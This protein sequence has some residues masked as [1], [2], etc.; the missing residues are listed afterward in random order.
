MAEVAPQRVAPDLGHGAGHLDA[1]RAA[2][3]DDEGQIGVAA[4]GVGLPFG[5][6]ESQQDAPADLERVLEA[7]EPGGERLP[8][9]VAEVGVARAGGDDEV[10]VVDGAPSV[11]CT[12]RRSTSMSDT[13][14]SSTSVFFDVAQDRAD[15]RGDVA[16]V[17]PGGGHLVEHRLEQVVIA[18]VHDRHPHGRVAKCLGRVEP[19]EAATEDEHV[20]QLGGRARCRHRSPSASESHR[21]APPAGEP[22]HVVR[23][24][25]RRFV[26]IRRVHPPPQVLPV[27]QRQER[28]TGPPA[29]PAEGPRGPQ[30]VERPGAG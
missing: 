10:V 16:R 28:R 7:L 12:W 24:R 17:E 9:I 1:G 18:A 15:G 11:K 30:Q 2:A 14:A 8:F 19:G 20:R 13:S 5:A 3:H 22:D 4:H 6:L 25:H 23:R 29:A 26:G 27:R 21:L